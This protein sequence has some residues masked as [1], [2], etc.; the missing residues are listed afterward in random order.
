[1]LPVHKTPQA[2]RDLIEIWKYIAKDNEENADR[3]YQLLEE[4]CDKLA[5][6]P[7]IGAPKDELLSGMRSLVHGN[8]LIFYKIQADCI[9]ILRVLHGAQDLPTFFDS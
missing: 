6:F 4:K 7:Q 5:E 9:V 8:Y 3:T 1:M 2:E